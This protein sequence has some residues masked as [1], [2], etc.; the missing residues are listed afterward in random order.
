MLPEE[1]AIIVF[2][3]MISLHDCAELFQ[4]AMTLLRVVAQGGNLGL[5]AKLEP[6]TAYVEVEHT[7]PGQL[8]RSIDILSWNGDCSFILLGEEDSAVQVIWPLVWLMTSLAKVFL[9]LCNCLVNILSPVSSV[10]LLLFLGLSRCSQL[11]EI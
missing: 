7:Q 10:H 5:L 8:L 2:H 3:C 6:F 1:A 4:V 11:W 9:S